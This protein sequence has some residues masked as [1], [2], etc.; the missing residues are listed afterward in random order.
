MV[1]P[2]ANL[3]YMC[4]PLLG[5][6]A[7]SKAVACDGCGNHCDGSHQNPGLSRTTQTV[8]SWQH[9]AGNP[10][11]WRPSY[12]PMAQSPANSTLI[13]QSPVFPVIFLSP[14]RVCIF[15]TIITGDFVRSGLCPGRSGSYMAFT[16]HTR[17]HRRGPMANPAMGA[18][19]CRTPTHVE[20]GRQKNTLPHASTASPTAE[21]DHSP[22]RR[23]LLDGTHTSANPVPVPHAPPQRHQPAPAHAAR[24]ARV[25]LSGDVRGR[26]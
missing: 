15:T 11:R 7:T 6:T 26:R 1:P 21:D 24:R 20:T 14:P 5:L 12:Q 18:C 25:R 17:T 4:A 10:V 16:L 19:S 2:N 9:P 8:T 3:C 23:G 13:G 22:A